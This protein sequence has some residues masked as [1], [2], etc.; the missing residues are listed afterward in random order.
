MKSNFMGSRSNKSILLNGNTTLA[1]ISSVWMLACRTDFFFLP[2]PYSYLPSN[3]VHFCYFHRISLTIYV[4]SSFKD[5][6]HCHHDI[7]LN[8][9][10][11]DVELQ[12]FLRGLPVVLCLTTAW[13]HDNFNVDTA[14]L[15]LKISKSRTKFISMKSSCQ[16]RAIY[17][18]FGGTV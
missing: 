4:I 14:G 11:V 7:W 15:P 2:H 5:L 1:L 9:N 3:C 13:K 8:T 16:S 17:S 12:R 6:S 18:R 10:T